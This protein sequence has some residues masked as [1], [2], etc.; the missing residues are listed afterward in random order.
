MENGNK[1]QSE[2]AVISFTY[3][4]RKLGEFDTHRTYRRRDGNG[5]AASH[6]PYK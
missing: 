6:L 2:R 3:E 5:T 4:E 1:T